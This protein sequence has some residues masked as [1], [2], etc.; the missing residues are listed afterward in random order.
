MTG[1]IKPPGGGSFGVGGPGDPSSTRA[2]GERFEATLDRV[3]APKSDSIAPTPLAGARAISADLRAGRL[4]AT[5]A[6]DRIVTEALSSPMA[7]GL[8][9]AARAELEAHLRSQLAED[10]S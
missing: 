6:V 9:P 7:L 2:P 5:A 10:P 1:P 4:E 8:D 3:S